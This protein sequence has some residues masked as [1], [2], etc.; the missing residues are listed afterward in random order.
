MWE[1]IKYPF[2]IKIYPTMVFVKSL[3]LLH[4][5]PADNTIWVLLLL[6]FNSSVID[7]F[8]P[9]FLN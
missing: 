9:K 5:K 1:L 2:L 8:S 4:F 7:Q 3:K 6:D